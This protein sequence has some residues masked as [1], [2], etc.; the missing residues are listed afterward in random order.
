[1]IIGSLS[2][3]VSDGIENGKKKRKKKPIGSYW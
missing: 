2:N 1:M 3:D